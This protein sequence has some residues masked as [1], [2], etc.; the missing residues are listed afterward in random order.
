MTL[1]PTKRKIFDSGKTVAKYAKVYQCVFCG[2]G[3]KCLK[4][5]IQNPAL[6]VSASRICLSSLEELGVAKKVGITRKIMSI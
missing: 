6:M 5:A 1:L 4:S 3:I 2:P